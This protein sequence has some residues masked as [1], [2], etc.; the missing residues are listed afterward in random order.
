[1]TDADDA[2][3]AA[4]AQ[5][6]LLKDF[7]LQPRLVG[8]GPRSLGEDRGGQPIGR[9]I[10]E[11]AHE[12]RRLGQDARV[13]HGGIPLL[14]SRQG[15]GHDDALQRW[16]RGGYAPRPG[17]GA[18]ERA[19]GHRDQ[20]VGPVGRKEERGRARPGQRARGAS[21][22]PLEGPRPGGPER[23]GIPRPGVGAGSDDQDAVGGHVRA[24]GAGGHPRDLVE[25]SGEADG[26]QGRGEGPDV[27]VLGDDAVRQKRGGPV[28]A[29]GRQHEHLDIRAGG[30]GGHQLES[31]HS[32]RW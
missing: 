27:E 5:E 26:G 28:D 30:A 14:G 20:V 8:D 32:L 18:D 31:G 2:A 13:R 6:L 1:L 25:L 21:G 29:R 22:G 9:L 10:D 15:G 12:R 4:L 24:Q 19:L 11:I 17:V 23:G 7:D 16:R 3:E